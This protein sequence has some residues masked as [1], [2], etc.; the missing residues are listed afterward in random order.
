MSLLDTLDPVLI[1]WAKQLL[2]LA[3]RAGVHPK[4]TS[5]RRSY[6]KQAALYKRFQEGRSSYPVARPGTS[7]HEWG[8]AFDLVVP[9]LTDQY[10]LGTVWQRWGGVYGGVNDPVHFEYPGFRK[11]NPSGQ[12]G[13]D[14]PSPKAGSIRNSIL[15]LANSIVL[16]VPSPLRGIL[17]TAQVIAALETAAGNPYGPGAEWL[18]T[19][20]AEVTEAVISAMWQILLGRS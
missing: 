2:E 3:Q 20:P 6:A 4:I 13:T 10:D 18:L 1:P 15:D 17:S 9:N 14:S 8:L 7:A 19:H 5:A 16:A 11:V 12:V